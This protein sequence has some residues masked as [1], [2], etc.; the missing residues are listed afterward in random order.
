MQFRNHSE[1]TVK[2]QVIGEQFKRD[3]LLQGKSSKT[4][5]TNAKKYYSLIVSTEISG[6]EY[7]HHRTFV[8]GSAC[9]AFFGL[10]HAWE[11]WDLEK[12]TVH[13]EYSLTRSYLLPTDQELLSDKPK[14]LPVY[15]VHFSMDS[16]D[17]PTETTEDM[18]RLVREF[19]NEKLKDKAPVWSRSE[20]KWIKDTSP[21]WSTVLCYNSGM[22]ENGYMREFQFRQAVCKITREDPE[23]AKVKW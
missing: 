17:E 18:Y 11:Y 4:I 15:T 16:S 9:V 14:L 8:E 20:Q 21:K 13:T 2:F 19:Y 12:S 3:I 23:K 6:F 22:I 7:V 1:L 10:R 5:R